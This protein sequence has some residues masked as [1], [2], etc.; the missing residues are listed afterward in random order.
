MVEEKEKVCNC[1]LD[2]WSILDSINGINNS[3]E[4]Y[5]REK[6]RQLDKY[7]LREIKDSIYREVGRVEKA[8]ERVNKSCEVELKDD[9]ILEA[10]D[11]RI[12]HDDPPEKIYSLT[13]RLKDKIISDLAIQ[14]D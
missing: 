14:C 1:A 3:A 12:E 2:L 5:H 6:R 4:T 8:I 10:L 11:H 9:G 7:A 13:G